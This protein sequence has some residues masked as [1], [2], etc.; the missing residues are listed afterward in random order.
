MARFLNPYNFVR[1]LP[2]PHNLPALSEE[3]ADSHLMWRCPPPPH[4]RFTGLSGTIECTMTAKTP[5]FISDG[6]NI[7]EDA[8][9]H[10]TYQFFNVNGEDI[11]P[12]ASLRGSIR[13]VFET[14]TN[15]TW[16]VL[17][18]QRLSYREP[19]G[20]ANDLIPAIVLYSPKNDRWYVEL[21]EG[22]GVH[23][24]AK[25]RLRYLQDSGIKHGQVCS[26]TLASTKTGYRVEALSADI[27]ELDTIGVIF[28]TGKNIDKKNHDRFF[29]ST[30]QQPTRHRISAEVVD[31]YNY[32]IKSTRSYHEDTVKGVRAKKVSRRD[33]ALSRF[34]YAKQEHRELIDKDNPLIQHSRYLFPVYVHYDEDRDRVRYLAPVSIPR[35]LEQRSFYDVLSEEGYNHLLPSENYNELSLADRVFGWV[36]QEDP[37]NKPE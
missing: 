7:R 16:A 25:I 36:H 26:A 20:V 11:I 9:G 10:K 23:K 29:F 37:D 27:N 31:D 34:H 24:F 14:V 1:P 13:S 33:A 19:T 8:N 3:S 22:K 4:D 32:L 6:D 17:S 2:A 35:V 28:A 15:S 21:L 18:N 5:I 30:S 12:A